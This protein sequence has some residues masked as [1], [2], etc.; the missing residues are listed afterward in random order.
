MGCLFVL[1][2]A[3]SPRLV[4]I[5]LWIFNTNFAA[6]AFNGFLIPLFGFLFLP[7]TTLVYIFV[8]NPVTGQL[9]GWGIFWVMLAILIDLGNYGNTYNNRNSM[10]RTAN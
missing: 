8:Y 6:R 4:L 3:I 2:A 10:S 5:L 7:F 1:L 9:S